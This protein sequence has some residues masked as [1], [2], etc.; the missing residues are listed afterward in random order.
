MRVWV[1]A[2]PN[3]NEAAGMMMYFKKV[4]IPWDTSAEPVEG[5]QPNFKENTIISTRPNQ[6]L[7]SDTPMVARA[8]A[9]ESH[10]L[11]CLRAARM[12]R[13]TEI[14]SASSMEKPASFSVAG[15]R[16]ITLSNTSWLV[17]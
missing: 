3:A 9:M 4:P 1:A 2:M 10:M 17:A 12:P 14:S 11:L 15:M 13:G 8:V 5:S 16:T 7:G 6:N